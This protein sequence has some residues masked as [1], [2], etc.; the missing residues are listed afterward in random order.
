MCETVAR[1][2][3]IHPLYNDFSNRG[4]LETAEDTSTHTSAHLCA[5]VGQL[6]VRHIWSV[7][8]V[9]HLPLFG[10][11]VHIF[12][13]ARRSHFATSCNSLQASSRQWLGGVWQRPLRP[14]AKQCEM[15]CSCRPSSVRVRWFI[16][17]WKTSKTKNILLSVVID[18]CGFRG[19]G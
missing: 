15:A 14:Q 6:L 5:M 1:N 18:I 7:W 16:V 8:G 19:S 9:W 10:M 17:L 3:H 2:A 11:L 4:F 13:F 12:L